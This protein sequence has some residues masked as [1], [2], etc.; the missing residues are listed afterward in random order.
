[1]TKKEQGLFV[2]RRMAWYLLHGGIT[3]SAA[4][5]AFYLL[6]SLFPLIMVLNSLLAIIRIPQEE[7]LEVTAVL[8]GAV[9]AIILNYLE[10]LRQTPA[11]QPLL[12]GTVLTLYFLSRAVRS[13]MDTF[14]EFYQHPVRKHPVYRLFISLLMTVFCI[15]MLA[16]SLILITVGRKLLTTLTLWF[17]QLPK[18][19]PRLGWVG[20][21]V[22][23]VLLLLFLLFCYRLL[24]GQTVRWREAFPGAITSLFC[25]FVLTRGF[26]FYVDTMARY[27][28]LYGSLGAIMILMLWLNLTAATLL[29]GAAFNYVLA[30]ELKEERDRLQKRCI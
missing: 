14:D 28:L 11:V 10:Y 18:W 25:W 22:A 21:V 2:V 3:R 20:L 6:F 4:E 8:P 19:L 27:N 16:S 30:V 23:T 1:M 24:P 12:L 26:A 9:Q 17:P 13:M 5:L 15:V 7:L 29:L